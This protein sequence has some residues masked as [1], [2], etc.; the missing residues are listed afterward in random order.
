MIYYLLHT[1]TWGRCVGPAFL[2]MALE[3]LLAL[4]TPV[5]EGKQDRGPN[6]RLRPHCAAQWDIPFMFK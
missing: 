2:G 1:R 3:L 6:P 5:P 4:T